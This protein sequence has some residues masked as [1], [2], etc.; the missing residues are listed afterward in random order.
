MFWGFIMMMIGAAFGVIGKMIVHQEVVTAVGVLTA[1][2]GMFLI[3]YPSLVSLR[4]GK[5][6]STPAPPG[7]LPP[8]PKVERVLPAPG[9]TDFVPSVTERTTNLL[10]TQQRTP[11]DNHRQES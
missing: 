2:V 7:Q 1:L 6:E 8:G 4:H 10:Q 11:K 9:A 5:T 3:G